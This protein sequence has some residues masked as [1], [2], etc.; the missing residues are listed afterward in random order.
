MNQSVYLDNAATTK[1]DSS[2][3]E[4]MLPYLTE[5]YGN[6]SSSYSLG[7]ETRKAIEDTRIL[8]A[9][10]V[11]ADPSEIFFTSS[12]TES[13]NLAI[14]GFIEIN[15]NIDQIVTSP[16]EHKSVLNSISQ[17]GKKKQIRIQ[18][19]NLDKKG[20]ID[21]NHLESLLREKPNSTFV[22]L[23]HGNNE[24]GNI[25]DIVTISQ[26]S[27]YYKC[28][29]HSDTVQ[30]FGHFPL[31]LNKYPIDFI[32]CSAHKIHGPKGIGLLYKKNTRK[33][34]PIFFGGEQEKGMRSGTE[35]VAGILAMGKA[36]EIAYSNI[37]RNEALIRNIKE[38]FM[39]GIAKIFP[40]SIFNGESGNL[41]N[42]LNTIVSLLFP[43][44]ENN[45]LLTQLDKLGVCA[46]AG[47]SCNSK[48]PKSHV[49][50]ALNVSSNNVVRFSFSRFTT[51]ADIS[52]V[53]EKFKILKKEIY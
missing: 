48:S 22:S 31:D 2:V 53:L 37:A 43:F 15:D 51:N 32:T 33:I 35:N 9:E 46:S 5:K 40:D 50:E 52:Y 25:N 20:M 24:I 29:F 26:L 12:S 38:N 42:S 28:V 1:M 44:F 8:I 30:T 16:I 27:N 17:V 49:M 34:N 39:Q 10:L 6:P 41:D 23:M 14:K 21:I 11:K 4:V 7:R 36:I 45:Y 18:Y 47:S 19:L 3:L 13:N